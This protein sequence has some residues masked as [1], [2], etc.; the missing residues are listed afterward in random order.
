MTKVSSLRVRARVLAA[1]AAIALAAPLVVVVP[2]VAWAQAQVL[3]VQDADIRVFIQD[4]GKS[5]NTTFVIDP[6]VKGTVSVTSNGPLNRR[7]LF[8][9]FLATLRANNLVAVPA[10]NG[11]YRVEPAENAARQP[12]AAGGQFAT[13]V[14]RL[15]SLDPATAADMLKPLVGPQGQVVA[16]PRGGT[17]VV[18]DY[19]DNIRRI[20]AL[21]S[22]VDQDRASVHTVTLTNSSAREIAQVINDLIAGPGADGKAGRGAVTVVPVESSNSILLRGDADAVQ[23]LLPL[24]TDLDRRAESS[25]DIRV[26]F[27]R[28]ANAEQMLPVL[29]QL[30][31]Q[32]PTTTASSSRSSTSGTSASTTA[33]PAATAASSASI[34]PAGTRASVARY[35]GANALIINAP[36]ETQRTLAEVIRQLDIRREQ[37]LVEAIV[38]EVSDDA[39][40]QLGVQ[41]LL[42]GTNGTIPF[43]GTNYTNISPSLFPL[44]AS[45]AAGND[46]D[47]D[48]S[49][50]LRD[51]AISSL[52]GAAGV[53]GG[54]AGRSGDVLFGAIINA[55]KKDS[56]SNLLSTPSIMTLDNEE[57]RILV[58]QQVP[59]TTGEVLGDNNANPFRTIQRQDVGVQLE[60]KPQ[61]NAGGGITLFLR[62]E[63][64]AVAGPISAGSTEL[65]INKREIETTALV[66]DGD[67]VVLGG[68]LDQN[69]TA[70][71]QR[72]PG[73]GDVP[74]LGALFRSKVRERGRTNLMVFI[75]PRIIKTVADARAVSLPRLDQIRRESQ[76]VTPEGDNS[77]DAVIRSFPAPPTPA[78]PQ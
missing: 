73:L 53:T 48:A 72:V 34:A 57:A 13:E 50:A 6:R 66:D 27:L 68:L 18:A 30:V 56:G 32:A 12:N 35:P 2:S 55:V 52:L 64:S 39:A 65:I 58:G 69:E 23:R 24:I 33:A 54:V 29:Q 16:N 46:A 77:L 28:H 1:S 51:S 60:V 61:I 17:V 10:G 7:E 40:K 31:G 43:M 25:D 36:P 21:L 59:I 47:T 42:G 78:Q 74:G 37:V 20:R 63:V 41:F 14:F 67:I 44:A 22:Q 3:N 49:K 15:R 26:V 5:T 71:V 62:Q 45:A 38:V 4:V 19:A 11:V 8:E 75:R 9:L 70:S 76:L